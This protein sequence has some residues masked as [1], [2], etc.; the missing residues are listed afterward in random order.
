M[1]IEIAISPAQSVE[2]YNLFIQNNYFIYRRSMFT[3]FILHFH[4]F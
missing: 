1:Q 4:A 2:L 3:N